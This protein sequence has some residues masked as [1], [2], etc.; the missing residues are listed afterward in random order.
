M[1]LD[2]RS[3]LRASSLT[4]F[5]AALASAPTIASAAPRA[6]APAEAEVLTWVRGYAPQARVV[7]RRAQ[8]PLRFHPARIHILARVADFEAMWDA[9]TGT[10]QFGQIY[11]AKN[12]LTFT[13]EGIAFTVENRVSPRLRRS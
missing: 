4:L 5:G 1:P 2:R 13:Y 6:I 8:N 10:Q 9:L 11:A 12:K 3:F 7:A